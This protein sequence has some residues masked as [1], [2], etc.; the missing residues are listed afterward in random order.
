MAAL[1]GETVGPRAALVLAAQLRHEENAVDSFVAESLRLAREFDWDYL[2]PQSRAQVLRRGA[3]VHLPGLGRE[4]HAVHAHALAVRRGRPICAGCSRRARRPVRSGEQLEGVA[5]PFAPSSAAI[6]HHLDGVRAD[7]GGAVSAWPAAWIRRS[8]SPARSRRRS[9]P[10]WTPSPTRWRSTRAWRWTRAP[11]GSSTRPTSHRSG[12]LSAERSAAASSG[13]MIC[14]PVRRR[15][16]PV[17]RAP[18]VRR[19]RA[20]RRVRRLPGPGLL[21]GAGRRQSVPAA[22]A[23]PDGSGG[24]GRIAGQARD[25]DADAGGDRRAHT[26]RGARDERPMAAARPRLPR[27]TP[28][29]PT[30]SCTRPAPR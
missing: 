14:G 21:V 27:S 2:K 20:L 5:T 15:G 8:G 30:R 9:S 12:L 3:G 4:S 6:P 28:T 19:W 11:M 16:G 7:D 26:R 13:P 1:R 24:D 10:R 18:R 22:G 17:Q 29:R 25:R 23:S